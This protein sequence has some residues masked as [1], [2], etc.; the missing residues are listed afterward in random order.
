MDIK[1]SIIMPSYNVVRYIEECMDSVVN[2]S[3]KEIEIICV[4]AFSTDGT[5]E[6]IKNY[7]EKDNRITL[8]DDDKKSCGYS[9][10]KGIASAKGEYIGFVETDD[11]VRSD[12]FEIL[13]DLA[14]KDHLDY[15]KANHIPFINIDEK[16]RY[17]KEERIFGIPGL[18]HLYSSM[19]DPSEHPEILWPDHCMWNGIYDATFLKKNKIRLNG[20]KG[21]S[22]QD[23]GFQWQTM[24]SAKRAVYLDEGLYFYRQDNENASMKDSKG[25]I[26]DHAEFMFVKKY[27]ENNPTTLREHWWVFYQKLFDSLRRWSCNLLRDHKTLPEEFND[28]YEQYRQELKKGVENGYLDPIKIGF[29]RYEELHMLMRSRDFYLSYLY[30]NVQERMVYQKN[31][32]KK[33]RNEKQIVIVGAGDYGKKLFVML[34]KYRSSIICA[35]AD[36]DPEKHGTFLFKKEILSVENAARRYTD[37]NFVIANEIYY[38]DIMRQLVKI[39]VAPDQIS[40]YK[41]TGMELF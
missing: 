6:I 19:I 1:V 22:Y 32:A 15:A 34:N 37:A 8:L 17:F 36:N 33:L 11:Y 12:M 14:S 31:I 20:S 40:Y 26:R 38:M 18:N 3:L 13:Y 7:A 23:H 41:I 39:G 25:M 2:Q 35:F 28:V 21:A 9:Y 27:L 10:N 29:K 4:D 5:R 16:Q 30:Q 24:C